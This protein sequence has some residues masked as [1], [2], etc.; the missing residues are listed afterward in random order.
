MKQLISIILDIAVFGFVIWTLYKVWTHYYLSVGKKILYTLAIIFLPAL[1]LLLFWLV[2][3]KSSGSSRSYSSSSGI[4][5]SFSSSSS[6][7]GSSSPASNTLLHPKSTTSLLAHDPEDPDFYRD[8]PKLYT[9]PNLSDT[10]LISDPFMCWGG[11]LEDQ[12]PVGKIREDE[13]KRIYLYIMVAEDQDETF[14]EACCKA[15]CPDCYRTRA[16]IRGKVSAV[17]TLKDLSDGWFSMNINYDRD[18]RAR[19]EV[20]Y[21][22]NPNRPDSKYTTCGFIVHGITL[23]AAQSIL[24]IYRDM[25]DKE[26][27]KFC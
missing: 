18:K 27:Y 8:A 1:G 23:D 17:T 21:Y 12:M 2:G 24:S 6:S 7:S 25:L 10:F 11:W 16:S 26:G 19:L 13:L 20:Y 22:N 3:N 4:S 9:V 15:G 5:R 14:Y